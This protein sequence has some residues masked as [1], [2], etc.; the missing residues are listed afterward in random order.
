[1]T[2]DLADRLEEKEAAPAKQGPS[3]FDLIKRLEPEFARALPRH[4][5]IDRFARMA[6][7][8]VRLNPGLLACTTESVL[9]GL[10]QAAQLGLEIS[11]VRGQCYLIPRKNRKLNTSE[12]TFQLGY[13]GLID[14]AWRSGISVE[15]R[16][17]F[18]GEKFRVSLG[19]TSEIIHEWSPAREGEPDAYYAVAHFDGR[20][21]TFEVMT[22]L[23]VEEHRDRFAGTMK[24]GSPWVDHFDGMA[25]KTVIRRLLNPLPLSAEYATAVNADERPVY[26]DLNDAL[27][28]TVTG[29]TDDEEEEEETVE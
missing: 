27:A 9:G 13:R 19:T 24:P 28:L 21:P 22:R 5:D 23:E 20:R 8:T 29:V 26:A 3:L 1:M 17:V 14:M 15:V 6:I 4:V 18:P 16:E 25:R 11:D 10:M 12:A 2:A 7:T